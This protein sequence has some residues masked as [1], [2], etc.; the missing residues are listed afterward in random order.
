MA[1]TTTI[2]AIALVI[3]IG[4]GA[5]FVGFLMSNDWM[6]NTDPKQLTPTIDGII[7]K[8]EWLRSSYYNIPFYLDV[9]N[10]V[11]PVV[12]LAN[13]D[14]WN[15]LSVAEDEDYYYLAL[16]LCSDRT[17]NKVDEW[18]ALHLA[19]RLPDTYNSKLAFYALEDFGYEYFFYD[20]ETETPFTH[21]MDL[22]MGSMSYYDIPIVPE[23]DLMVLDRGTIDG[24][25]DDIWTSFDDLNIT[26]TSKYYEEVPMVWLEGQFFA[27]QFGVNITEKF[28]DQEIGAFMASL[29]DM[30]LDYRL[31]GNLTSDPAGHFGIANEFFGAV[32]EHGGEQANM[33]EI[34]YLNN[35]NELYFTADT[36][37]TGSVDLDHNS[38]NA[39]NGMFYFSVYG[40]NDEDVVESTNFEIEIDKLSLRFTVNNFAAIAGNTIAPGNYEIA[41]SYGPSENC[42]EDHRQFEFKI[43]KSEFPTLDDEILYLNLAGYGT[44]LIA[45]TNYW[46]YPHY[47]FPLPPVYSSLMDKNQFLTFDMSI[48]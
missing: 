23:T 28:P 41:Y 27:L 30:D 25:I 33:S 29:T 44:M 22:S 45:G 11:D 9:D 5:F 21:Y 31:M 10:E 7:E 17:N 26:L 16:D 18:L 32:A 42:P 35:Y 8:R 24:G 19:N 46:M 3:G 38:I 14:G 15:Y 39:T 4:G 40:W 48:T 2:L 37:A 36:I 34:G 1:K 12:D 20:V 6:I 13:V 43:A 47:G